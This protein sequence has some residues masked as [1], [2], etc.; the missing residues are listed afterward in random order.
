M[1]GGDSPWCWGVGTGQNAGACVMSISREVPT[2]PAIGQSAGEIGK[3]I[4]ARPAYPLPRRKAELTA[5]TIPSRSSGVSGVRSAF[6]HN[7]PVHVSAG[8]G[9]RCNS[10]HTDAPPGSPPA[11]RALRWTASGQEGSRG[12]SGTMTVRKDLV[13]LLCHQPRSVSAIARGL[14][15]KRGDVEEDVRHAIRSA[16][17][18]GYRIVVIPARCRACGFTFDEGKLSKPGKC[19]ACRG[20]R[21]Y[22]PQIAIHGPGA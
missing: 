2:N 18:A 10:A 20:T 6:A 5:R 7:M 12:A 11:P 15:L 8:V 4:R 19:P 16:E 3:P 9:R 14:G 21:L 17:A 22:E 13:T 1:S